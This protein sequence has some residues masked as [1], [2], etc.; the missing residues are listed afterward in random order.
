[1]NA[2]EYTDSKIVK[3][4][5]S[6]MQRVMQPSKKQK[7]EVGPN[8]HVVVQRWGE[9]MFVC[10][11]E[12]YKTVEDGEFKPSRKRINLTIMHWRELLKQS[13]AVDDM[14]KELEGVGECSMPT[15]KDENDNGKHLD[16]T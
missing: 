10:I 4:A 14:I 1:M 11:R 5:I 8:R 16:E 13:G 3:K 9:D 6:T 7:V 15:E 12:Y 2:N